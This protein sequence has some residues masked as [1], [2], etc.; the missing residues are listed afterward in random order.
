MIH[1]KNLMFKNVMRLC[2]VMI[3]LYITITMG[4]IIN[5]ALIIIIIFAIIILVIV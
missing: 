4:R 1:F 3:S 2:N 5:M